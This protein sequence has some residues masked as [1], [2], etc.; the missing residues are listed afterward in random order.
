MGKLTIDTIAGSIRALKL[1]EANAKA[2]GN[3][4]NRAETA[5][6]KQVVEY[7]KE[8]KLSL[9]TRI[10]VDGDTI[11]YTVAEGTEKIHAEKWLDMYQAG[12]ITLET[13]IE[14][15]N[16]KKAEAELR[17]GADVIETIT[18]RTPGKKRSV[19]IKAGVPKLKVTPK[20]PVYLVAPDNAPVTIETQTVGTSARRVIHLPPRLHTSA[21]TS[22]GPDP[23]ARRLPP[24]LP[25]GV[26]S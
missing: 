11:S 20:V 15:I 10:V 25:L 8:N 5:V 23:F 3:E 12:T 19:R 1:L 24:R 22:V 17:A 2:A 6:K 9:D 14:C 13:F 21:K 4:A 26:K 7:L 18:E 16:V